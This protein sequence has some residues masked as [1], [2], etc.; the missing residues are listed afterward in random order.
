MKEGYLDLSAEATVSVIQLLMSCWTW[1]DSFS[2][3]KGHI[4]SQWKR[5]R[6]WAKSG[7]QHS[8]S[9]ANCWIYESRHV[10]FYQMKMLCFFLIQYI[11]TY[12]NNMLQLSSNSSANTKLRVDERAAVMW[13][14]QEQQ[15]TVT[16]ALVTLSAIT[17][18]NCINKII[19]L[20]LLL[21]LSI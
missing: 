3:M 16:C 12:S 2:V 13:R 19:P 9:L 10:A 4:T 8:S 20:S 17:P 6:I 1:W 14:L 5:R 15:M 7:F 18:D 21:R 11:S